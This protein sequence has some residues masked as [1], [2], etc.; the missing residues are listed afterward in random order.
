MIMN[1]KLRRDWLSICA[2][3]LL[4]LAVAG[5][6]N[7]QN[8][9]KPTAEERKAFAGDPSHMPDNVKATIASQQAS[10]AQKADAARNTDIKKSGGS[11]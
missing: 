2:G 11:Q 4:L 5:C 9:G 7:Q 6:G 8:D 1:N 10:A 3:S